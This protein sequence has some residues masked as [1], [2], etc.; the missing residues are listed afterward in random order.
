MHKVG[1]ASEVNNMNRPQL[2]LKF[3]AVSF[4]V[5]FGTLFGHSQIGKL[6]N[7]TRDQA[8][9]IAK[10]DAIVAYKNLEPY[11][12]VVSES[13]KRW[14]VIFKL[15]EGLMGGGPEYVISKKTGKILKKKYWQ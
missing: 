14:R 11:E 3:F 7:V 10:K 12:I 13:K 4:C 1:S 6:Q 9:E 2:I 5:L 8:V 15:K